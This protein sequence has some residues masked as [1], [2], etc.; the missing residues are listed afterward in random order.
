MDGSKVGLGRCFGATLVVLSCIVVG[1]SAT[2]DDALVIV[3]DEWPP[4]SGESL[5]GQGVSL[6][7][8]RAVLSRAGYQVETA[9][10][11]WSRVVSGAKSGEYDVVTSLFLDAEMQES[12]FYSD[13]FFETQVQFLQRAGGA[14]SFDG[15]SSL[16][17]YGI[18]VGAGFLYEPEFDAA[19][20]LNKFEVNTALQGVQMVAAGRI[21]LTLGSV[22]VIRHSILIEDPALWVRI[23]CLDPPAGGTGNSYGGFS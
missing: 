6:D 15:L 17:P 10:L 16:E 5:P 14:I 23:E 13:P 9:I 11:P 4:F 18:A 8:T 22:N 19:E 2:A 3:A 20:N 7:V 1:T 21:V 12:L